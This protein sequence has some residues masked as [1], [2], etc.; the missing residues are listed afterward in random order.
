MSAVSVAVTSDFLTKLVGVLS[1]L[2]VGQSFSIA[3]NTINV[4]PFPLVSANCE[5]GTVDLTNSNA[6]VISIS[7][8]SVTQDGLTVNF[9]PTISAKATMTWSENTRVH[10]PSVEHGQPGWTDDISFSETFTVT[11]SATLAFA[12]TF[13][14]SNNVLALAVTVSSSNVTDAQFS[15]PNQSVLSGSNWP[16]ITKIIDSTVENKIKAVDFAAT[17]QTLIAGYLSNLPS[18]VTFGQLGYNF[19]V[20][21]VTAAASNTGLQFSV[22]GVV[23]Y[24]GTPFSGSLPTVPVATIPSSGYLQL[25]IDPYEFNAWL[26][27][28]WKD[29]LLQI[30]INTANV[31]DPAELNTSYYALDPNWASIVSLYPNNEMSIDVSITAQPLVSI[32]QNNSKYVLNLQ[33][34]TDYKIWIND[35]GTQKVLVEIQVIEDDW[36]NNFAIIKTTDKKGNNINALTFGFQI[37]VTT[38]TSAT[39]IQSIIPGLDP[40][41]FA[42]IWLY[43]IRPIYAAVEV[44]LGKT[45]IPLPSICGTLISADVSV[46]TEISA[47]Y[48]SLIAS[49]PPSMV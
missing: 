33:R 47:T 3:N 35:G 18:S 49:N 21:A 42:G 7:A 9:T 5:G 32:V 48:C 6:S 20:T 14:S 28:S 19:G 39:L 10:H 38:Q 13:S 26:W 29:N 11:L 45:G 12:V 36:F 15:I 31:P 8:G 46:T 4:P 34:Q 24:Q 43:V 23:S 30:T 16:C 1:Q 22:E 40:T 27:A 25:F 44:N 17:V 37:G 2:V 41:T